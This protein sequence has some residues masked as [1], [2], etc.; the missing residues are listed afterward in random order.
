VG[1]VIKLR[2]EGKIEER[3]LIRNIVQRFDSHL[4]LQALGG[5]LTVRSRDAAGRQVGRGA[6]WVVRAR[7]ARGT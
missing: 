5:T 4:L 6:F 7:C 2:Q 1:G 3:R